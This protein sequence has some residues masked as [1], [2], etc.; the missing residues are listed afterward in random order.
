M[1]ERQLTLDA[2]V[3]YSDYIC[4]SIHTGHTCNVIGQV[5]IGMSSLP[6]LHAIPARLIPP[7]GAAITFVPGDRLLARLTRKLLTV[8]AGRVE[9]GRAILAALCDDGLIFLRCGRKRLAVVPGAIGSG[10][11]FI[12]DAGDRALRCRGGGQQ[13]GHAADDSQHK[14]TSE[15]IVTETS[16]WLW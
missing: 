11:A 16:A 12:T 8:I 15:L 9:A 7:A 5:S 14:D 6:M 3:K 1:A 4:R 10:W 13:Q 2:W